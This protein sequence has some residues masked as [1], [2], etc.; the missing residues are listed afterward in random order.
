MGAPRC[1]VSSGECCHATAGGP[2]CWS[3]PLATRLAVTSTAGNG[4]V[5]RDGRTESGVSTGDAAHAHGCATLPKVGICVQ[6]VSG[7]LGSLASC[8]P[9][10]ETCHDRCRGF[11]TCSPHL[12]RRQKL[13]SVNCHL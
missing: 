10:T 1:C 4:T 5:F 9:L 2:C 8:L 13:A 11:L 12:K 6:Q 7:D 3:V